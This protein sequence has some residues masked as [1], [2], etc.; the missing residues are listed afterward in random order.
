MEWQTHRRTRSTYDVSPVETDSFPVGSG[1]NDICPLA[2]RV[3]DGRSH[4]TPASDHPHKAISLDSAMGTRAR[5][6][7]RSLEESSAGHGEG[8]PMAP[9]LASA[10]DFVAESAGRTVGRVD[11]ETDAGRRRSRSPAASAAIV[12]CRAFASPT[13]A[14]ASDLAWLARTEAAANEGPRR[15]TALLPWF[16]S[17]AVLDPVGSAGAVSRT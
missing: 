8:G 5:L 9:H 7:S 11:T 3:D 4:S 10:F 2:G 12:V 13:E 15:G 16:G 1:W 14:V 17:I 6:A